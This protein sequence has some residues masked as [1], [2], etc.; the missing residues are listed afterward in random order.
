MNGAK[1]VKVASQCVSQKRQ[2]VDPWSSQALKHIL[3]RPQS[4]FDVT[5][6]RGSFGRLTTSFSTSSPTITFTAVSVGD[7]SEQGAHRGGSRREYGTG[8][9]EVSERARVVHTAG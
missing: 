1:V 6:P 5:A 9:E 2:G 4:Q 7:R 3:H 8:E